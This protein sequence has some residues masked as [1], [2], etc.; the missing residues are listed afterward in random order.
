SN[1]LKKIIAQELIN[2]AEK[3]DIIPTLALDKLISLSTLPIFYF[4]G[5]S[6]LI[7]DTLIREGFEIIYDLK[8]VKLT[9][10]NIVPP[11]FVRAYQKICT[12]LKNN[13]KELECINWNVLADEFKKQPWLADYPGILS[14]IAQSYPNIT[15]LPNIGSDII[16]FW[17]WLTEC[18]LLGEDFKGNEIKN[19]VKNLLPWNFPGINYL[20]KRLFTLLNRKYN[21]TVVIFLKKIHLLKEYP[22]AK[23][24]KGWIDGKLTQ[25]ECRGILKYLSEEERWYNYREI[26]EVLNSNWFPDGN[27]RLKSLEAYERGLIPD[28]MLENNEFRAWLGISTKEATQQENPRIYVPLD[29]KKILNNIY[30]WWEKCKKEKIKEYEDS[31]YPEGNPPELKA[32][33]F[34]NKDKNECKQWM[35]LFL[36]ATMHTMGRTNPGQ[37]RTFIEHC[38]NYGW[39]DTFSEPDIKADDWIKILED[40]LDNPNLDGK[41]YQWIKQFISIYQLAR[42]LDEYVNSFIG[43]DKIQKSLTIDQI[44]SPNANPFFQGGGPSAPSLTKTLG[45]GICFVI[46]ELTRLRIIKNEFLYPHCYV[47]SKSVRAVLSMIGC[48]GLEVNS[49]P[50][51]FLSERIYQFLKENIGKEKATFD[52]SFDLPLIIISRNENLQNKFLGNTLNYEDNGEIY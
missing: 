16:A 49:I 38:N 37:N 17:S 6:N 8:P 25:D 5:V 43:I 41:Y 51:A 36:L 11:E 9:R 52:M 7:R 48:N 34:Y 15:S 31:V 12:F 29:K 32:E 4:D 45:I 39:M 21:E 40:Y 42:W 18:L 2:L 24:I 22:S 47:P 19:Y 1:E 20:P 3:K 30:E 33:K 35:T 28:N 10:E 44:A 23:Q 46:R 14:A 50:K 13:K 27:E 26:K